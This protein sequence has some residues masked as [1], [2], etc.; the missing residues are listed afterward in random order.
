MA[1]AVFGS[2]SALLSSFYH[3]GLWMIKRK[4][5]QKLL[6]PS[7]INDAVFNVDVII[8]AAF[9]V[10]VIIDAAFNVDIIIDAAFNVDVAQTLHVNKA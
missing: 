5:N 7:T 4:R 1:R 8:D 2:A 6:S 3:C 10:D 9:N